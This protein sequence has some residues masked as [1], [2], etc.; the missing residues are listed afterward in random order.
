MTMVGLI[1]NS[2]G[3]FFLARGE[4][5]TGGLFV[6]VDDAYRRA[7][8]N[9]GALRGESSD[10]GAFVYFGDRPL[11]RTDHLQ[12]TLYHFLALGHPEG[13]RLSLARRRGR[14]PCL[15]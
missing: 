1:G 12:R 4:M 13:G 9:D 3:A 5:L 2:V 10:F 8:W 11:L 15:M 7:G 14:C 6:P